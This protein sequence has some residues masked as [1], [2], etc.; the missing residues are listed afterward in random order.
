VLHSCFVTLVT[1]QEGNKVIRRPLKG[2][3][4]R[5]PPV[6]PAALALLVLTAKPQGPPTNHRR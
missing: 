6:P 2:P 3:V 4:F 1:K 5:T